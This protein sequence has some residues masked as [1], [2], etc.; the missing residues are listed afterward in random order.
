MNRGLS[1]K[2]FKLDNTV[3]TLVTISWEAP[4]GLCP[5][6]S[7]QPIFTSVLGIIQ[8][9]IQYKTQKTPDMPTVTMLQILC[10]YWKTRLSD[11]NKNKK[12]LRQL[13][14]TGFET[15]ALVSKLS[16][17]TFQQLSAIFC[18]FNSHHYHTTLIFSNYILL[19]SHWQKKHSWDISG[20]NCNGSL[21][22]NKRIR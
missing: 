9:I 22:T 19:Y 10:N 21:P 14:F 5:Q 8:C 6:G 15:S 2:A 20:S 4:L 7:S 11:L 12:I 3:S 18:S 16:I 13:T 1:L 17:W